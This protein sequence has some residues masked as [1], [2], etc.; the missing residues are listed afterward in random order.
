VPPLDT[1]C[2]NNH[3]GASTTPIYSGNQFVH[4]GKIALL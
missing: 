1:G 3:A 4:L 2:F